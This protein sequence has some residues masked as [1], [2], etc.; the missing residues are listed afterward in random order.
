MSF[1]TKLGP[2]SI[3][4]NGQGKVFELICHEL[5]VSEQGTSLAP[6]DLKL[7]I[8][9]GQ[10]LSSYKPSI[11]SAKG[12]MNFNETSFFVKNPIKY[13]V[14]GLF[15]KSRQCSVYIYL[16]RSN[17]VRRL[18]RLV[19]DL[20]PSNT[21][22][23][24]SIAAKIMSYSLFWYIF[25]II[26]LKKES[27]FIHAGIFA[28]GEQA[29]AITGTGG[30]GKTSTLFKILENA[31]YQYLSEDF[32]IISAQGE[33]YYNPKSLSIYASD[34]HNEQNILNDYV[35][36]GMRGTQKLRWTFATRILRKNPLTKIPVL[37][38][39]SMDRTR[40]KARLSR[41]I[42]MIRG[43]VKESEAC[44]I[45]VGELVERT[46]NASFRELKWL[47]ENMKLIN[48]NAP[49][50]YKYPSLNEI[51]EQTESIYEQA[52]ANLN[53]QLVIVPY[54]SKPGDV[55]RFLQDHDL[56]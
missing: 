35:N 21:R 12:N 8:M 27:S 44:D 29:T 37:N 19:K 14:E 36:K 55:V 46:T 18:Y 11:F 9:E 41:V 53:R 43:D 45:S 13:R 51:V 47:C 52:F 56:I 23:F 39:L 34:A 2:V 10:D 25:H 33:A 4:L 28:Q 40:R 7:N 6:I 17:L 20:S 50:H 26:L 54:R 16:K 24:D 48:A 42:Y 31:Q 15:E 38:L 3:E 1:F 22:L 49:H 32:G 5:E 30:S